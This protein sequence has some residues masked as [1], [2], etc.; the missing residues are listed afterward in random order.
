MYA[1]EERTK[2]I[3]LHIHPDC[4]KGAVIHTL[5]YPFRWGFGNW[6]L[7]IRPEMSEILYRS[8]HTA[9]SNQK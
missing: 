7:E 4:R 2:I 5:W 3:E 9:S 8:L 1:F 6:Y